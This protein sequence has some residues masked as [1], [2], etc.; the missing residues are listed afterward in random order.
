MVKKINVSGIQVTVPDDMA[1]WMKKNNIL[2]KKNLAKEWIKESNSE[3]NNFASWYS[4]LYGFGAGLA[5]YFA[6]AFAFFVLLTPQIVTTNFMVL[7]WILGV[8]HYMFM[9]E[10]VYKSYLR[11]KEKNK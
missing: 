2:V 8:P 11:Y 9:S 3:E 5:T 6:P 10:Q 7:L 1:K 4:M